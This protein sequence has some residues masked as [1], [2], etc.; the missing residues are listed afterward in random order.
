MVIGAT[1]T[2]AISGIIAFENLPVQAFPDVQNVF[3]QVVTQY[4]GQAPEEVEK[5]ISL[6]IERVMNGVPM[7][8]QRIIF[9]GNKY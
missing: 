1:L 8:V 5:L 6:P 3:V 2:I 9:L 4:P 7:I